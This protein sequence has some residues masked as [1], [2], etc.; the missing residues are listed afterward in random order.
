MNRQTITYLYIE[1][2]DIP[3]E[4]QT[5]LVECTEHLI[6]RKQKFCVGV[7]RI[8]KTN[9]VDTLSLDW[10]AEEECAGKLNKRGAI[11]VH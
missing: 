10:R 5:C 6:L 8:K 9:P 7:L 3:R 11:F 1:S 2:H 4:I